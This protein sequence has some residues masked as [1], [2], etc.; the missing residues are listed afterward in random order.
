MTA[1][2]I[3]LLG[4][5]LVLSA[6]LWAESI[7]GT[8]VIRKKLTKRRVT[9]VV[10]LYQRGPAVELTPGAAEDPLAFER[11][12]VAIYLDGQAP[13]V[14]AAT[15]RTLATMTQENRSFSP[16]TLVI[17]ADRRSL[18]QTWIRSF[19]TSFPF[20]RRNRSTWGTIPKARRARSRFPNRASSTWAASCIRT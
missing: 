14:P 11:E 18:F 6:S 1:R 5:V 19:T 17:A 20:R 7:D 8:V 4:T 3:I 2:G 9:A 10:P 13:E 15:A 16:E 12:R